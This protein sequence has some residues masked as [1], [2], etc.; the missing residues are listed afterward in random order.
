MT[1]EAVY[2]AITV[3]MLCLLRDELHTIGCNLAA[4]EA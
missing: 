4:L 3:A 1:R 2:L